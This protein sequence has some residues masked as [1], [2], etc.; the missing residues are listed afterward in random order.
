MIRSVMYTRSSSQLL[1][2]A[3]V[4]LMLLGKGGDHRQDTAWGG[5]TVTVPHPAQ[6]LGLSKTGWDTWGCSGRA[7]CSLS[8]APSPV[9]VSW[10]LQVGNSGS[11]P[12]CLL[13]REHLPAVAHL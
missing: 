6:P 7:A 13:H 1:S 12:P 11:S 3:A 2:M 4:R 8:P 5:D 9:G 10:E